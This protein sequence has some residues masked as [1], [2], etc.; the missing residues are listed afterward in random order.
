MQEVVLSQ[1]PRPDIYS[2]PAASSVVL[3]EYIAVEPVPISE[4]ARQSTQYAQAVGRHGLVRRFQQKEGRMAI[5]F[6]DGG[7]GRSNGQTGWWIAEEESFGE[8][9]LLWCP[10]PP[11]RLPETGWQW[12]GY[13]SWYEVDLHVLHKDPAQDLES[14]HSLIFAG[15]LL[16]DVLGQTF[17][18]CLK[19]AE[20]MLNEFNAKMTQSR[21]AQQHVEPYVEPP[22][23]PSPPPS[24]AVAL[25][26]PVQREE[27]AV[28]E[29]S[30]FP[31]PREENEVVVE[32]EIQP[33]EEASEE[34]LLEARRAKDNF[35]ESFKAHLNVRCTPEE[36]AQ[37]EAE[38]AKKHFLEAFA[39]K[40][41][42][43][44]E[45]PLR[46]H[47]ADEAL[48][49]NE[50]AQLLLS[51]HRSK[52]EKELQHQ[53]QQQEAA[54][55]NILLQVQELQKEL[56]ESLDARQATEMEKLELMENH[57]RELEEMRK[58]N[59]EGG[60][61]VEGLQRRSA[62]LESENAE[63]KA[64]LSEAATALWSH[65]AALQEALQEASTL[66]SELLNTTAAEEEIALLREELAQL[67]NEGSAEASN[68]NAEQ[69]MQDLAEDYQ[70]ALADISSLRAI[71]DA[72][73]E[74]LQEE[75][76]QC[77]A[78]KA[79]E[80]A[81][82][83]EQLQSAKE[84]N[85]AA[86]K[87]QSLQDVLSKRVVQLEAK[88]TQQ[89]LEKDS[90]AEELEKLRPLAAATEEVEQRA[91][92]A[93]EVLATTAQNFQAAEARQLQAEE[94]VRQLKQRC[95]SLEAQLQSKRIA[96]A[97]VKSE[98][99]ISMRSDHAVVTKAVKPLARPEQAFKSTG[100][101][102]SSKKPIARVEGPLVG[103]SSALSPTAPNT[104]LLETRK[105]LVQRPNE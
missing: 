12:R 50:L 3:G 56:R 10:G 105:V 7:V 88:L 91:S 52:V 90:M 45:A 70:R 22:M 20:L 64:K 80:V 5:F 13:M 54:M 49:S 16:L 89:S 26:L 81:S 76:S 104:P 15:N 93:E 9:C 41:A 97:C 61:D 69:Q 43:P 55:D 35:L 2:L 79:E 24:P 34:L 103:M 14:T 100:S 36:E 51:Q 27:E 6:D 83:Q 28:H 31:P 72:E 63:C 8:N 67:R 32:Q 1:R 65:E 53:R 73:I 11:F 82:L 47:V 21:G 95:Q 48:H 30:L 84:Q 19:G 94:M 98:L 75:V 58:T 85:E 40:A 57:R 42:L 87:S 78:S 37:N 102:M 60:Q 92:S 62:E 86:K 101:M 71:Y 46:R 18:C 38:L 59:S 74:S 66:R 39:S 99:P 68:P 77:K 29:E 25:M 96:E 23:P 4:H 17:V 44:Q 33:L